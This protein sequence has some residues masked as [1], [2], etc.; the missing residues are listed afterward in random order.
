MYETVVRPASLLMSEPDGL[1]P[2]IDERPLMEDR[3]LMDVS[4]LTELRPLIDVSPFRAALPAASL[5]WTPPLAAASP[6][7]G[8]T[9]DIV[10]KGAE[11]AVKNRMDPDEQRMGISSDETPVQFMVQQGL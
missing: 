1:R 10:A 8:V 3:P 5:S 9:H 2:L 4:P 11:S 7:C 6:G